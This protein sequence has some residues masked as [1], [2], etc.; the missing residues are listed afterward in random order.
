MLLPKLI[1]MHVASKGVSNEFRRSQSAFWRKA[2]SGKQRK[3]RQIDHKFQ[4]RNCLTIIDTLQTLEKVACRFDDMPSRAEP[5]KT[6]RSEK[7][8]E[9]FTLREPIEEGLAA[10]HAYLFPVRSITA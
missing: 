3:T 7:V 5:R 2:Q 4:L 8:L 6:S 10:I 9:Y 1:H